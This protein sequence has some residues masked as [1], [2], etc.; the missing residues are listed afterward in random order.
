MLKQL[1]ATTFIILFVTACNNDDDAGANQPN[2]P[3]SELIVGEWHLNRRSIGG[4]L[5]SVE[6]CELGTTISFNENNL[7]NVTLFIGDELE[8]CQSASNSGVWQYLGED[9]VSIQ[10]SG[11][12][13]T[14]NY[15]VSFSND[16]NTLLFVEDYGNER[17]EEYVR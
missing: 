8:E 5:E 12:E 9:I 15:R 6:F 4:Q 14:A 1:L 17:H 10:L 11:Q 16:H 2:I 13:T 3:I 7:F